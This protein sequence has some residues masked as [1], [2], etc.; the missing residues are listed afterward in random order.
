[1]K[2]SA[3]AAAALAL[4]ATV[5]GVKLHERLNAGLQERNDFDWGTG[6]YG[7]CPVTKCGGAYN[8]FDDCF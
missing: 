4:L 7:T 8:P 6:C 5:Q 3:V 2:T 1:M